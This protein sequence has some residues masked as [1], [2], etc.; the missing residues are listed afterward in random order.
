[1]KRMLIAL[2]ML[3][4]ATIAHAETYLVFNGIGLGQSLD[5]VT[6]VVRERGMSIQRT[7]DY[8]G[9]LYSQ[10]AMSFG[11]PQGVDIYGVHQPGNTIVE[12]VVVVFM[13]GGRVVGLMIMTDW[14]GARGMPAEQI[15]QSIADNYQIG[16]LQPG[17]C[18]FNTRRYC[19]ATV[20]EAGERI[21]V[22]EDSGMLVTLL[23][24]SK[25]SFN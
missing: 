8:Y 6:A 13:S 12:S 4:F 5:E 19:W 25:P 1:M 24:E 14:F 20:T 3:S 15:A 21:Y 11:L 18:S 7:D 17:P 10:L 2:A 16:E 23:S 22:T 9:A